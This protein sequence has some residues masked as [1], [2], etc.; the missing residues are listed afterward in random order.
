MLF[1]SFDPT[2]GL[3]AVIPQGTDPKY[4]SKGQVDGQDCYQV[5]TTYTAAQVRN[6]ISELD[7]SGPVDA[8]VWVGTSDHLVRKAVLSGAFGDDGTAATVEVTIS[9]FNGPV[10]ISFRSRLVVLV[11]WAWEYLFYDRPV[12]LIV[13]ARK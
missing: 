13:R 12:R 8:R 10:V 4:V 5:A 2:T 9:S 7:S 11:N 1:R 6:L 3:P